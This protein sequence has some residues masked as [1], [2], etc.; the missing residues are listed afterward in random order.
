[1]SFDFASLMQWAIGHKK[2]DIV[3]PNLPVAIQ[4]QST[5]LWMDWCIQHRFQFVEYNCL[6]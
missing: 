4:Q 6:I 3:E 5:L 2:F 1:M